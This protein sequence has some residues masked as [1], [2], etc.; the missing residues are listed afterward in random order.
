MSRKND[1]GE[2]WDDGAEAEMAKK[3][4]DAN[5][6]FADRVKLTNNVD[7]EVVN[8]LLN[9]IALKSS[10]AVKKIRL[11][12]A[13]FKQ[14]APEGLAAH[15]DAVLLQPSLSIQRAQNQISGFK[16]LGFQT[17]EIAVKNALFDK[18]GEFVDP[19]DNPSGMIDGSGEEMSVGRAFMVIGPRLEEELVDGLSA[20]Y[21]GELRGK[22]VKLLE[23]WDE[24]K[25][26]LGVERGP[27]K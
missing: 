24:I 20:R 25:Q 13:I 27:E 11:M 23:G 5:S 1:T 15:V 26:K 16:T 14:E 3:A 17:R 21:L 2:F 7:Y 12:G 18:D 19:F 10:S 8:K 6:N 22:Q 4:D 9:N